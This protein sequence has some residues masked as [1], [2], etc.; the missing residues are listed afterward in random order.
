M[1]DQSEDDETL[2]LFD[3][4]DDPVGAHPIA[5]VTLQVP[6]ETLKVW[7]P[8]RTLAEDLEATVETPSG[9]THSG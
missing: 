8:V 2:P 1:G 3:S 5:I 4:V 7:V 9:Q 6:F